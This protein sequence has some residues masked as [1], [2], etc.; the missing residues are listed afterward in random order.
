MTV[1]VGN[2]LAR[3]RDQG[4]HMLDFVG[5]NTPSIAEFKRKFGSRIVPYYRV[6]HVVRPELRVLQRFR[7]MLAP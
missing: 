7:K 3:L 2:L 4:V 5:A 1:L 6:E